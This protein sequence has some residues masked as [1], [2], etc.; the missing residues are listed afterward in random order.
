M[1]LL[2]LISCGKQSEENVPITNDNTEVRNICDWRSCETPFTMVE[3]RSYIINGCEIIAT[4]SIEICPNSVSVRDM[5][6]VFTS[7]AACNDQ[8]QVWN[9]FWTHGQTL[10]ANLAYNDFYR[11][12]TLLIQDYIVSNVALPSTTNAFQW[13]ETGCHTLCKHLVYEDGGDKL[14]SGDGSRNST[15]NLYHTICGES[16]CIRS[17]EIIWKD[18]IA[19]L[20]ES[21]IINARPCI[22]K[23]V[24]CPEGY[25]DS[26]ICLPACARL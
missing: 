19:T 23:P 14:R 18:G 7:S 16:C 13:I 17:T 9:Q 3:T 25:Y 20:G 8:N 4:Y 24:N 15:F 21:T 11:Q 6:F 12:I 22:M 26:N 2:F 1:L 10:Q 5:S